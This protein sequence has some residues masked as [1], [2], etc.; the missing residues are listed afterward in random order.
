[1]CGICGVVHED[2]R[3]DVDPA[4]LDAMN[5]AMRHRGPDDSG[6][7]AQGHVGLAMRRLSILDLEG[8]H[9]PLTNEDGS[10]T[11]VFNGEIYN[12]Q[13]LRRDLEAQGHQFRTRTDTEVLVHAYEQYGD[14]A[15]DRLNGM[16][17]F[18]LYDAPRD[19]LLVAR[20]RL[21]IKPLYYA[22]RNGTL[23]FA[24]ELDA[25]VR[26]GLVTGALD[27]AAIDAYFS[28]LYIPAPDTVF[29][30][31]R[32]LEPGHK[33]VFEHGR[34]TNSPYWELTFAPKAS[35]TMD[36]AAEVYLT[37][38]RDAVRLRR[39]ADVPLGAFLSGGI[40][41]STV[42]AILT[43]LSERPVK[44]F[45]I[46]FDDAHANEMAY[47]RTAAEHLGT[48]H[49]EVM[50]TPDMTGMAADLARHFG[51]PF[52]DSS[53][54]PTWLVSNVA[55]QHVTVALSGDGGDELFA[56]YAWLHMT[57][58]VRQYR[59]VPAPIRRLVNA[60]L[61]MAPD[62]PR[63]AKVQRFSSDSFLPDG[64]VFRRRQT[65]FTATQRAGLYRPD[66]ARAV[67][68]AAVDRFDEWTARAAGLAPDE[69]MLHHD[70]RMY[71]PDDILTKVDR[72]SMANG[73]EA[74]VPLLDHRLVEFAAT[75]PFHLKLR[76]GVSKRLAKRAVRPFLPAKLLAQRKQG[77][78]IP[79]HR[80]FRGPLRAA[81]QDAVLG[82]DARSQAFLDRDTVTGLFQRHAA[83]QDN[84]GH[85]LWALLMFEH[86]LRYV[87]ALVSPALW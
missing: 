5:A 57:R 54:V 84:Y 43:Q 10:I 82:D 33:L 79:I 81:F 20:D 39:I 23:A 46:G 51:E 69:A 49:V 66:L 53:A 68:D 27:P 18:A 74:R 56:G 42:V 25:L 4:R 2:P 78:A 28:F 9:Q 67:A 7:W 40:D 36:S 77:F 21:G 11:V 85:H 58:R 6:L 64:Q 48:D 32:K 45:T 76:H 83:G 14:A 50:L 80:W 71:L 73:L 52:A 3:R 87:E 70:T 41:S 13:D 17:A 38:L 72:M 12:F 55:R 37:L 44:T 29:R 35:W 26:S 59:F 24:S 47:A 34:L 60:A 65:C 86:W 61:R 15:L 75:V 31:A 63:V 16:F 62:S 22:F 30:D 1:V 19:R 8:G